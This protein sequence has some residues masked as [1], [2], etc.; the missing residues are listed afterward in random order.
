MEKSVF[1]SYDGK[2]LACYLYESKNP[3]KVIQIAHGMQ[4]Y[5][6][7]YFEFA[8]FLQ[9]KG[10]TVFL[11]DQRGHGK[12]VQDKTELGKV[13]GDIFEKTVQDHLFVSK[14]LK[15]KY[16]VPLIFIGHSYG[17]FIGQKYLQESTYHEKVILIGSSY[18]NTFL[19]KFANIVAKLQN[20]VFGKD[21]PANLIESLSVKGYQ[22]YFKD[23]SWITSDQEE[24]EKFANDELNAT[25]FPI[26][27][28]YYMFKN[29]LKL[30][31][32]KELEKVDKNIPILIASGDKDPV[33]NFGKGTE[34][35]FM[36]YK[37]YGL[38]VKIKLYKDLRHGILQEVNKQEIYNDMLEFIES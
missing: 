24:T 13:D 26:G 38:N 19:I 32:K 12:S 28:Y 8:E 21:K 33:G 22:K 34:R 5:S 18:M 3:K 15:E 20:A 7:T 30:Y 9:S 4:E 16:N 1:K 11:F 10:Y 14:M 27:F 36:E 25:V 37:K 2:E 23:A 17:S 35:L 29:Q 6:R 31:D